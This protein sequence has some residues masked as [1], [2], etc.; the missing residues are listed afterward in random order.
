MSGTNVCVVAQ[1]AHWYQ[2]CNF[3]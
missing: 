2:T 3:S 1:H